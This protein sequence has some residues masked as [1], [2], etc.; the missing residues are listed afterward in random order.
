MKKIVSVVLLCSILILSCFLASCSTPSM[1]REE[2]GSLRN[3]QTNIVYRPAALNYYAKPYGEDPYAKV[4]L[5]KDT[6]PILLHEIEGVDPERYLV[7]NSYAVYYAEGAEL[8]E[9]YDLP[10]VR[11][12]I[13]DTQVSSNDG[14]I[15]DATEIQLLKDLHKNGSFTTLNNVGLY[16][17]NTTEWYDLHFM[18]DG[19]YK[20]VYY[21]LKY[22]VF[23]EDV[24]IT[25]LIERDANGHVIDLYPGVPYT[26]EQKTY[27]GREYIVAVYNFGKEILCDMTSGNCYRIDSTL[28][29]YITPATEE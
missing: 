11:V 17:D 29:P 5:G 4:K 20:G 18:G 26:I 24:L 15:T 14:N 1:K 7:S 12:G 23:A 13:Y 2:N 16:I 28:I 10:C 25:E 19:D 6:D 22:G 9:L 21:Q 8:P 27:E 3:P